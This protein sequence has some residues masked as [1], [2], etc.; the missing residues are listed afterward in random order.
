MHMLSRT[1][2][3]SA[4]L[5]TAR[6]P[7]SP[8]TVVAANGEVQTKEEATVLCQRIGFIRDSK[9]TQAVLSLGKFC[10][11]HGHSFEWTSG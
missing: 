5:E 6:V 3:N 2:L 4:E 8:P 7:E 1:D 11:D 9:D 10:Q